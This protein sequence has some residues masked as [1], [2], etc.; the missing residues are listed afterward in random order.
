VT[1]DRGAAVAPACVRV[2]RDAVAKTLNLNDTPA[3]AVIV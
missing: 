3:D 2:T 1:H